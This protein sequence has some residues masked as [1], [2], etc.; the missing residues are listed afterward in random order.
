MPVAVISQPGTQPKRISLAVQQW[1]KIM[2]PDTG[3]V[4]S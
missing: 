1:F 3:E 2:M 4:L